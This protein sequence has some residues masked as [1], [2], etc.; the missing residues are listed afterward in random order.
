MCNIR[1]KRFT[2]DAT[3]HDLQDPLSFVRNIGSAAARFVF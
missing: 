1:Q 3:G 2:L